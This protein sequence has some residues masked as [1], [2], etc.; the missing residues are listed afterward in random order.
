MH[1]DGIDNGAEI[2][3]CNFQHIIII[4]ADVENEQEIREL[5]NFFCRNICQI[6]IDSICLGEQKQMLILL[7]DVLCMTVWV[8]IIQML[9]RGQRNNYTSIYLLL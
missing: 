7:V 5:I 4:K 1:I 6:L 8:S 3:I 9:C 2:H